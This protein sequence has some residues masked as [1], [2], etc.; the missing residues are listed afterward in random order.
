MLVNYN[1][2]RRNGNLLIKY[3][4][5]LYTKHL[6][7]YELKGLYYSFTML[8]GELVDKN[9]KVITNELVKGTKRKGKYFDEYYNSSLN[10]AFKMELI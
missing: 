3:R 2:I 10:E 1:T 5:N 9:D 8:N 6:F 7:C 4:L